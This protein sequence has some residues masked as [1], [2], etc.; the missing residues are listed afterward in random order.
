MNIKPFLSVFLSAVLFGL[1]APLA[2]VLLRDIHPVSLAGILYLGAFFGLTI[3]RGLRWLSGKDAWPAQRLSKDDFPWLLG[4]I[5]SGGIAAPIF[6]MLGLGRI[7]GITSSLLLNL[8]GAATAFFAVVFFRENA[9][10]R[11]WTALLV[12]T[13][14]GVIFSWDPLSGAWTWSGTLFILAAMAGWG[15]DNNFTRQISHK[16]GVLLAQL[17]GL[18]AGLFST[19]AALTLG[20]RLPWGWSLAA[21]LVVGAFCYGFSLVL[22]IRALSGL[23]ALRTGA[24]FSAAPFIGALASMIILRE[25]A[26]WALAPGA[27]LMLLGV[28]LI[29]REKHVHLHRHPQLRHAHIHEHTDPHHLHDHETPVSGPHLHDHIHEEFEHTHDHC[30]DLHHRHP[31]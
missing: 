14:A 20:I 3:F 19:G 16:D 13:I 4:A 22:F 27:G 7:S 9:S 1:G 18:V 10:R 29:A 25:S 2:K 30:P 5:I 28:I 26:S 31:H 6:L 23:G 8:E 15:L 24:L 11:V 21:G 17:K 12:M